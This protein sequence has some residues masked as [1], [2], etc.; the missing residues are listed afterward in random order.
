[1]AGLLD[2]QGNPMR[3]DAFGDP[4]WLTETLS[5]KNPLPWQQYFDPKVASTDD[6][7]SMVSRQL[8]RGEDYY[9]NVSTHGLNTAPTLNAPAVS[10]N[11]YN[12]PMSAAIARKYQTDVNQKTAGMN[13]ATQDN[14]K[15]RTQK[16]LSS[17]EQVLQQSQQNENNNFMQ[18]YNFQMQRYNLAQQ[19]DAQV[20]AS[21]NAFVGDV[22]GIAFGAAT[23]GMKMGG[24][25]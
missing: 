9:Q 1:M 23:M 15:L 8:N 7:N 12:N 14:S 2:L 21:K 16:G 10:G 24:G 20:A 19:H 3:T 22:L 25:K 5:K 17:A 6:P 13:V 11:G 18:Q 4:S